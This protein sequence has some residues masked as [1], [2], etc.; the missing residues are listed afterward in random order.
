[1]AQEPEADQPNPNQPDALFIYARKANKVHLEQ[2]GI[3]DD[4]LSLLVLAWWL[5]LNA[6]DRQAFADQLQRFQQG[7]EQPSSV[8]VGIAAIVKRSRTPPHHP[9]GRAE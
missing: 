8:A 7:L 2:S 3:Q 6:A 1:M 4:E 5:Q 9:N